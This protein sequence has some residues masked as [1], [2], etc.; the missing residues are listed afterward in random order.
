MVLLTR[1][2]AR[3]FSYS[4]IEDKLV[5]PLQCQVFRGFQRQFWK[6]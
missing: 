6:L 4:V 1:T 5:G 3:N 2:N